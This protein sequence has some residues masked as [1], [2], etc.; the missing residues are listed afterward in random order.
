MYKMIAVSRKLVDFYYLDDFQTIES[1][2]P[3]LNNMFGYIEYVVTLDSD[4]AAEHVLGFAKLL[5]KIEFPYK[6]VNVET[7]LNDAGLSVDEDFYEDELGYIVDG[8]MLVLELGKESALNSLRKLF[9][10]EQAQGEYP[11]DRSFE[12]YLK[13][14][15]GADLRSDDPVLIADVDYGYVYSLADFL[16]DIFDEQFSEQRL[17]VVGAYRFK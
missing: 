16:R 14:Y 1:L 2:M 8:S 10:Y 17:V 11:K 5:D 9:Q 7:L 3:D 15:E 4:E 6:F 13:D 12:E